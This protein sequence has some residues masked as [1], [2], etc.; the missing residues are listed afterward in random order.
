MLSQSTGIDL[1]FDE[2]VETNSKNETCLLDRAAARHAR[3]T[4]IL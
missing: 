1:I 2:T 3:I 4:V